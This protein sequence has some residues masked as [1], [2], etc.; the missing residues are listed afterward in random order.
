MNKNTEGITAI[1]IIHVTNPAGRF[2]FPPSREAEHRKKEPEDQP[3]CED[4]RVSSS[5]HKGHH[6]LAPT[7]ASQGKPGVKGCVARSEAE[8][9]P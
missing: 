1:R 5:S 2:R 4:L 6:S 9:A 8:L 7:K 3:R